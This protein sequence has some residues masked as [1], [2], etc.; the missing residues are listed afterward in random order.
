MMELKVGSN[1]MK[2]M[3]VLLLFLSSGM[4]QEVT[5][6]DL[7]PMSLSSTEAKKNDISQE[8]DVAEIE[9]TSPNDKGFF[10]ASDTL[11]TWRTVGFASGTLVG[12]STLFYSFLRVAWWEKEQTDFFFHDDISYVLN[13]DK[14]AHFYGGYAIASLGADG[15][16]WAGV[17]PHVAYGS[18]WAYSTMVQVAIDFKDGY[19]PGFG[20]SKWDVI[21]GSLGAATPWIEYAIW[22]DQQNAV[23]LKLSYYRNSTIYEDTYGVASGLDDYTNQ[24][25][26]ITW[27]PWAE[28]GDSHKYSY[29][30][31]IWGLSMGMSINEDPWAVGAGR[32]QW[33][34]LL[35]LDY[36]LEALVGAREMHPFWRGFWRYINHVKLPAPMVMVYPHYEVHWA[37]PIRF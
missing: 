7:S 22:R 36:N 28:Q 3:M 1:A 26:Y 23:D 32:G 16:L 35:G 25:Y 31:K 29:W 13:I 30:Q 8:T 17:N 10:P 14:V 9:L 4:G 34:V 37:Y 6:E 20:F 2:V 21:S 33:E 15:L 24:T 5:I 18:A 12:T 19:T 11:N 27:Y